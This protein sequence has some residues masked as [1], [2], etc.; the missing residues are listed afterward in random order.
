MRGHVLQERDKDHVCTPVFCSRGGA[1]VTVHVHPRITEETRGEGRVTPSAAVVKVPAQP[2]GVAGRIEG[3]GRENKKGS[4]L[5]S[6]VT[7]GSQ[8]LL[9]WSL[10]A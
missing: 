7:H 6:P 2:C 3:G 9:T 1:G 4:V 8:P 5:Q 10:G